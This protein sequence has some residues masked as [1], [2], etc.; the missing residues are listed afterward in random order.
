MHSRVGPSR[1]GNMDRTAFD[2]RKNFFEHALNGR[3]IR[4]N[5]PPVKAAAIVCDGDADAAQRAR[6]VH[7]TAREP[8]L[9]TGTP[10]AHMGHC[11]G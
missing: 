1:A 4:L 2:A 9:T 3:K 11:S 6:G 10:S 7:Y 8:G 5:L